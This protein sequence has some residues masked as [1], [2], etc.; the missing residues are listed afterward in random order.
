MLSKSRVKCIFLFLLI[1][2]IISSYSFSHPMTNQEQFDI[3]YYEIN[4]TIDPQNE[5]V[6]GSVTVNAI[7]LI[8]NLSQLT[9]DLYNNM[10]VTSVSGNASSFTHED[11]LLQIDLDKNYSKNEPMSVTIFYYGHPSSGTN[12]NPMTFDRSRSVVTISSESCPYY[13][14]CWWPCKDRPDDK[15]DSMDVKITVPSNL[16]VASNGALIEVIKNGDGTNT[17]HWQIQYPIATYLV[18]FTISDYKI[19]EDKYINAAQDTLSIMHFVYPEHYNNAMVDFDNVNETIQILESYYGKYPY[20]NEKYGLAE[21]VGYWGGMEYQ[22]LS[23]VQPYFITGNHTYDDLFVHELAHQW[24]GDCVTPKDFHHSWVSEGFATFTE[25][26]YFGHLEGEAKYHSYMNN[27][28]NASN[29]KGVMYRHDI[30]DPDKVYASI[31]YYKG[32]WVLHML[33]HVVGEENFWAGLREYRSQFEYGSATTEDL[34][35]VFERVVGVGDSLGWFF[36]QWVYEPNYPQYALGWHREFRD[37][38]HKLYAFIRQDQTDAP[39]F[40]MPIDLTV[41]TT[42]SET[43]FSIM[44]DD[45]LEKLKYFSADSITNFQLDK[46]NWILKKTEVI[47]TPILKYVNHQIVDSTGNNNGLAEPGESVEILIRITNKG[48]ICR[49]VLASLTSSDP[50]LAIPA[51]LFGWSALAS[52][53]ETI[54]NDLKI[55]LPFSVKPG[56][57]GHLATFKLHLEAYYNYSTVDSFDVKIGNPTILLVDDDNGSNYERYFTQPM[58]LAKIYSDTWE[59]TTQSCPAYSEVL[60]KYQTV[61]WFTGDD[62]STSLTREEQQAIA[63]YLDHGGWLVLTGQDIGYDL[64]A[65]GSLEDSSFFTDYLHAE[66]LADTVKSTMIRGEPGDPI[67]NGLFIYLEDKP[68]S[69]GNQKAPSAIAPVDGASSF[70]KYIPQNSSAGIRYMDDNKG[71]RLVY[72]AFGFEGISGP[73]QDSAQK[74]LTRILNWLSGATEVKQLKPRNSPKKYELE[75]NYPNPFNPTTKI[76]YHLL[77]DDHVEISIYN[78]KGQKIKTLLNKRQAMGSYELIWDGTDSSGLPI[79]SG[80]YVYRLVTKSFISSRKLALIK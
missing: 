11:N 37:E 19:I 16:T 17:Y 80:V 28:N 34:Q 23:S 44:V 10:T 61:I 12:F 45:S 51:A 74:L 6:D 38:Q 70:L 58:S 42:K 15:P 25:A 31:V 54:S 3:F 64:L 33:R 20:Y 2:F 48:I 47:T 65:D 1:A 78:L 14:R 8:D 68:G 56:T 26:L 27:E 49:N 30:S 71:Y 36:H 57:A 55:R 63:E 66:F 76:R 62:R 13:A 75:Q 41:T 29:L 24:W 22:T 5:I 46:D 18:S 79:A 50:S 60:Q 9:L 4:I 39:L 73:Y 35:H 40:K 53:Y 32:A 43:T 72:L 52:D 7:S 77:K 21:Y 67:G 59:V 69:A